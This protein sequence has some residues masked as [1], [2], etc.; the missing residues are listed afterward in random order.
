MSSAATSQMPAA[1]SGVQSVSRL[2]SSSKPTVCRSRNSWS[3]KSC[4]ISSCSSALS[5]AR[6]VPG[7]GA[8]CTVAVGDRRPAWVDHQQL[9]RLRAGQPV[10]DPHP[11]HRLGLGDV[12]AEQ[13]DH[14]GKIHV[15]VGGRLAVA[16]EGLLQRLAGGGGA[17]PGVAVQVVGAQA[18]SGDRGQRVV[19]LAEQ[20]TG[21]VEAE[22]ARPV[23]R[24]QLAWC[25]RRRR[26]IAVSQ[27]VGT[28][29]P[30][31][32]TSGAVSRSGDR[33]A[34]QP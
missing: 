5:S 13:G 11:Q 10:Q 6:L 22:R 16:A 14:V 34:C 30:P 2:A 29:W 4:S 27:S 8:R 18:R 12:V 32:R 1:Q 24:Q 25:G 21:G 28:S 31:S 17:E 3:T 23:L 9:R 7:R 33:L 20:L 15:G 26:S 19:L